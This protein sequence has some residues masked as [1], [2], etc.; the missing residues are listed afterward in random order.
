MSDLRTG[1]RAPSLAR[2][3]ARDGPDIVDYGRTVVLEHAELAETVFVL[4]HG[5]SAS[6][7]QFERFAIDLHARGHNVLVPRLPRHGY[8]RMSKEMAHLTAAELRQFAHDSVAAAQSLGQSI[9]VVGFSLGGMLATW[10]GLHAS[11]ERVVAIAPFFGISWIPNRWM[12]PLTALVGRM[13]NQFHWWDPVAREKLL[14]EH[15]YPRYATHAVVQMYE[16]AAEVLDHSERH[17]PRTK[18]FGFVTNA[19]EAAVNNRAVY[20][21]IE[22]LEAHDGVRVDRAH[23]R[24]LPVSHDI[25]EPLHKPEI[26]NRVYPA[27]L[28]AILGEGGDEIR[29]V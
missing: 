5:L 23:L 28:A 27:L 2:L 21:L 16:L 4:F 29:A 26:A 3:L 6:P 19:R 7:K 22:R 17:P 8:D 14:P 18:H 15:G 9:V 12:S 10:S 1:E 20:Q 25:V 11:V 13:P 24:N